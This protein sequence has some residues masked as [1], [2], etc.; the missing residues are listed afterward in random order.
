[1]FI[2]A[3]STGY[4]ATKAYQE[5]KTTL[6]QAM[7]LSAA[8]A[9]SGMGFYGSLGQSFLMTLL[10]LRIGQWLPNPRIYAPGKKALSGTKRPFWPWYLLL[11]MFGLADAQSSM[12]NLSDGGHNGDNLGLLPLI[13]RRCKVI[14]VADFEEDGEFKFGSLAHLVRMARLEAYTTVQI[15]L[16][17]LL[18][19]TNDQGNQEA[20]PQ[21]VVI[22][23]LG[24]PDGSRGTLVYVKSSLS[25]AKA[26]L[27]LNTKVYQLAHLDFPHQSTGDQ[28]FDAPQYDAYTALGFHLG[29]ELVDALR[30]V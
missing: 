30:Q 17:P 15:D 29:G 21:G 14:V 27:P 20:G 19:K 24:Y 13:Q 5:G 23:H 6:S 4:A 28:F 7:A 26:P 22:G 25:E 10:N 2:G 8:A 9:N 16:E 18:P 1:M 11:E 3:H 12:I